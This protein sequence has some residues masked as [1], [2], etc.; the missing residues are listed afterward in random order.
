MTASA[1]TRKMGAATLANAPAVLLPAAILLLVMLMVIPVPP[2]LLDIGF[3]INIAVSLA[4]LMVALSVARPLDFSSFPTVLLFATVFRLALNV[5]ST[6]VVLVEGHNG[7]GAAG[8]VIEAFGSFLIAGNILVGIFVFVILLIINL[9]V[10]TKGAGRVSEVSA[11]FVLD[12]LPG[13]QMAIDADL[14]AGILTSEEAVRRRRDIATEADFYGS[15]DGASKFVKGDAIAGVL[16]LVVN[17]L[18]GILIGMLQH[19]M[20]LS[21][22]ASLFLHLSIG[23]ALVA[24]VPALLLSIAAAAVVTRVSSELDLGG[25]VTSQFASAHAWGAA[26]GILALI[27]IIPGMPNLLLLSAAA[28]CGWLARSVHRAAR[29]L[30]AADEPVEPLAPTAMI[31]WD[32]VAD[33]AVV[34]IDLGLGLLGLVDE[35][36]GGQLMTRVTGVRRQLSRDLGFVIPMV[37]VTDDFS[38]PSDEYRISIAGVT[39]GKGTVAPDGL[40]AIAGDTI[41][42]AVTGRPALDPTYGLPCLWIE[43]HQRAEAV[44]AGYTVIDPTTVIATHLSTLLS[45]RAQNVFG[46]EEVQA[47]LE[48]L[49]Q[50]SPQLAAAL[51]TQAVPLPVLASICRAL[52][53]EGISLKDFRRIADATVQALRTTSDPIQ[54]V[55]TIREL[56]GDLIVQSIV[57]HGTPLPVVTLHPMLE[58][59][60]AQAVRIAPGNERPFEPALGEQI[61]SALAGAIADL[62]AAAAAPVLV[63]SPHARRPLARLVE[64]RLSMLRV[65]SYREIPDGKTVDMLGV[66]GTPADSGQNAS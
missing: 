49:G 54:M 26:A 47:L 11:R 37:R 50:G 29:R 32:E 1:L 45:S 61:I 27:G 38:A 18:G 59:M 28:C 42:E 36:R 17:M 39:V 46:I 6:R 8:Q 63:T 15:M 43:P 65:L 35:A 2:L 64:N 66:V 7:P 19:D 53:S 56:I 9:V 62:D 13:K 22:A 4:V 23:D 31:G 34:S 20:G 44:V 52:L 25:Q 3:I 57:P 24:Q 33:D 14:N 51:S 10:I 5:A 30:P 60:L 55:E 40:M 16:I 21:D 58:D 48:R 12:A 41:T